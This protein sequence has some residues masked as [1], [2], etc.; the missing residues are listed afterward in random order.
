VT[1][2]CKGAPQDREQLYEHD[3]SISVHTLA[4]VAADFESSYED[5]EA[6]EVID[7]GECAHGDYKLELGMVGLVHAEGLDLISERESERVSDE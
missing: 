5:P 6:Y 3:K 1:G 7:E 4:C 2:W